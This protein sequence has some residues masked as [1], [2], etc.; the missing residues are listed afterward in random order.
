MMELIYSQIKNACPNAGGLAAAL[1]AAHA[2][3]ST[4]APAPAKPPS[5]VSAAGATNSSAGVF[6]A[7]LKGG[8]DVQRGQ[9][10][11]LG[12]EDLR[13]LRLGQRFGRRLQRGLHAGLQRARRNSLRRERQLV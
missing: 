2:V 7:K 6:T 4:T 1:C 9:Q 11:L 5:G 12:Q 3:A 13:G 8:A 10:P